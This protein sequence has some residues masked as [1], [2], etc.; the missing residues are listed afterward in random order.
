MANK[1]GLILLT[2]TSVDKTGTG[3][4]ATINT[5]GSVTFGSCET[6]SLNGVFTSAYDNYM[7][8]MRETHSLAD[9]TLFARLRSAGTDATGTADYNAQRLNANSTTIFGARDTADGTWQLSFVSSTW[10]NGL[11][12]VL[13]GPYLSQPTAFRTTTV[14]STNSAYITDRAGTHELSSSYDGITIYPLS[15]DGNMT[16]LLSVYGLR[17]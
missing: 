13:Y 7:I 8:V 9:K 15:G 14:S 4:T 1:N 12:L 2:P 10:R 6:L 5:N 11:I 3:S 17:N 16:G